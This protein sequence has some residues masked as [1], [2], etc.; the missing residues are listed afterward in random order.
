MAETQPMG[1]TNTLTS[2]KD[3]KDRL[4]AN[5]AA[6]K[7]HDAVVDATHED[8]KKDRAD[9]IKNN[10]AKMTFDA[11]QR[12]TPTVDEVIAANAG[13]NVPEKEPSGGVPQDPSDPPYMHLDPHLRKDETRT[14]RAAS[15]EGHDAPY[16]TR[17]AAVSKDQK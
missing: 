1:T 6:V 5:D 8:M 4:R 16:Q 12:P 15:A 7:A 13:K 17:A 11:K 9:R 14:R 3:E 2:G 10:E